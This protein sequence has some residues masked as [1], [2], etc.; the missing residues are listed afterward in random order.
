MKSASPIFPRVFVTRYRTVL[1]IWAALA[2]LN[3]SAGL[4]IASWPDRQSDLAL[5]RSW[6]SDWL[7]HGSDLYS[8][9]GAPDYPPHALVTFSPLAAVPEQWMVPA[10]ASLNIGLALLAPYLAVRWVLPKMTLPEAALPVLMLLTWGGFRTLLQ[11]TLFAVTFGLLSMVLTERASGSRL[12]TSGQKPEAWSPNTPAMWSGLCLALALTKPQIGAAFFLWALFTRRLR[13]IAVA[14]AAIAVALAVY[15]ARVQANPLYVIARYAE[16]LW[17]VYTGETVLIGLAQLRPLAALILSD[18]RL[19]DTIAVTVALLMLALVVVVGFAEGSRYEPRAARGKIRRSAIGD[20]RSSIG[21]G[22]TDDG[23]WT[24]DDGRSLRPARPN[25]RRLLYSAPALAGL[26]SLLSFY[27]LTY[28]FV[29]LLPA[30]AVLMFADDPRT[31]GFRKT[32]FWLLQFGLVVDVPGL[33]R[34]A[35]PLVTV[36]VWINALA[37]NADRILMLVLFAGMAWLATHPPFS[38]ES[39]AG[40]VSAL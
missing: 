29:V 40:A 5:V 18:I 16:T 25:N 19:V 17:V 1:G 31:V 9:A 34:Q 36:P 4:V 37:I 28:G 38:T 8:T 11:F 23:R 20:R 24:M 27:H 6:T 32:L 12:R 10:W 15:C 13:M 26:W 35:G 30:A 3:L 2:L 21:N 14:L 7:L 22:D 39:S 33:W